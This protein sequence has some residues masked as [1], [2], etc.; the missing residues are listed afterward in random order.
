MV[1]TTT[2]ADGFG[3][4]NTCEFMRFARD[5]ARVIWFVLSAAFTNDTSMNSPFATDTLAAL[6]TS[7]RAQV[8]SVHRR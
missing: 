3:N 2:H 8:C 4:F 1:L 7:F 6:S 5:G